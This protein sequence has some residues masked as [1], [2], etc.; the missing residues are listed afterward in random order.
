MQK[1][2]VSALR[3]IG[4][5]KCLEKAEV[6]ENE[7]PSIKSLN[8]RSLELDSSDI[9]T[10]AACLNQG[11]NHEKNTINSI[12]FSYNYSLGDSGATTLAKS[13]PKSIC[14]I[15]LVDCGIGDVGGFEILAWMRNS[16]RL[17]MICME[18]NHFSE[19]LRF[20]LEKFSRGNPQILVVY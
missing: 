2:I 11:G 18:Q 14:E 6:L 17:R 3:E 12:S 9:I 4:N 13:L 7:S 1:E 8:L 20:E 10:I 16:T 5:K 15:G 19:R